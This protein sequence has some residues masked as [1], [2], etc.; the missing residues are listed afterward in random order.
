MTVGSLALAS[1]Y[2]AMAAVEAESAEE[3]GLT[4]PGSVDQ[5]VDIPP[6]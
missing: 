6:L 4:Y 3:A 2:L 5:L 1:S